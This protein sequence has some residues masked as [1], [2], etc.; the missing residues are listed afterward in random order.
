MKFT[1]VTIFPEMFASFLDATLLGKAR[2]AG[3]IEV[4]FVDPRDF[5]S[6]RHRTV[7]DAPYGGGPGMV[8][9]CGPLLDAIA[10]APGAHRVLMSPAGAPLSQA[11]VRELAGLEHVLIVCGRYEG[12][13]DRVAQLG[14]DEEISV[15]DFVLSGGEPAAMALIDAVSRYVPGVLGASASVDE[16]SFSEPLLEYPQY[17]RPPDVQGL[18]VPEV[19]LGG[20]HAAIAAWRR[21]RALE[22]TAARRP[23]LL[24][25]RLG[26][27]AERTYVA[28]VHHPV[29][30]REREVV[31]TSVTNLDIHD[32]ARSASTYG[33]A[34]Y[35]PITPIT[36]QR[37]MVQRIVA[38]W[39][40]EAHRV[41]ARGSALAAVTPLPALA[42]AIAAIRRIHGKK[43][44]PWVVATTARATEGAVSVPTPPD[45]APMLL[46]FGTGHGLTDDLILESNQVLTPIRGR[47]EFNH[48]SVRSAVGIVLDRLFGKTVP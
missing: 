12:V 19:L 23:D 21:E 7:D 14:I 6:D 13:D 39:Q 30:D 38:N 8:M 33:L 5:T 4:A 43:V 11:R 48:L 29:Y 22:R 42:D 47:S 1:V 36:A 18:T 40:D 34:G 9:Q 15:G 10:T 44:T 16:E 37:E 41:E 28:L 2:E 45:D 24:V 46:V 35:F 25:R 20:N 26:A 32:I 3:L 27:F 31:T 17:T